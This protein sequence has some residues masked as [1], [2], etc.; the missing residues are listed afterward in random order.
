MANFNYI[1]IPC[2]GD[3]TKN[4]YVLSSET[5][6]T[7]GEIF[8]IISGETALGCFEIGSQTTNPATESLSYDRN[9]TTCID[10]ITGNSLYLKFQ[11]CNDGTYYVF[12]SR[13]YFET[14]TEVPTSGLIYFMD[15]TELT[16][17][18]LQFI[19]TVVERNGAELLTNPTISTIYTTCLECLPPLSAGTSV[20]ICQVCT[21][22]SGTTTATFIDAPHP[23]WTDG[24]GRSVIQLNMIEL[25][26]QNG[27]NN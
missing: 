1:L 16:G 20:D 3:V 19:S 22:S 25:G 27:L 24:R 18:C 23:T 14:I 13:S 9:Y 12:E 2:D 10:C 7:I 8:D 11:N 17:V 5:E 15:T 21:D 6:L 4:N 26:G